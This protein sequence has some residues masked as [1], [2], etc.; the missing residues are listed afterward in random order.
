MV[1]QERAG[2]VGDC[3]LC[4]GQRWRLEGQQQCVREDLRMLLSPHCGQEHSGLGWTRPALLSGQPC[5]INT[6]FF[7]VDSP[8]QELPS[9]HFLSLPSCPP[10]RCLCSGF[11]DVLLQVVSV[12]S[13]SSCPHFP[14]NSLTGSPVPW[15][16]HA[17]VGHRLTGAG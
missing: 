9:P 12:R 15:A 11:S 3:S 14:A 2:I 8:A 17:R 7:T 5:L 4:Q 13:H 6:V 1:S 10:Q 16:S